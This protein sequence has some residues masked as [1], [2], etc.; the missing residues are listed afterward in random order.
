MKEKDGGAL[1]TCLV[2]RAIH[3]EV[4]PTLSTDSFINTYRR[5][6][7]RRGPIRILRCDRGTNFVRAKNELTAVLEEMDKDRIQQELLKENCDWINFWFNF[8]HSSHMG[9]E[10]QQMINSARSVLSTLLDQH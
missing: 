7:G 4:A 6:I 9:G 10:W 1:F 5:F 3:I 8:S 2:T